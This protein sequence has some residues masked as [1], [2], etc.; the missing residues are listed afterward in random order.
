MSRLWARSFL[1]ISLATG[2]LFLAS[3]GYFFHSDGSNTLP[4][5]PEQGSSVENAEPLDPADD[6]FPLFL[7]AHWAYRD[8]T[9]DV[10]PELHAGA[11]IET[12]VVGIVRRVD[13]NTGVAYDCY[14]LRTRKI[15]APDVLSYVHRTSNSLD[16][17]GVEIVQY[18]GAPE[19]VQVSGEQ[20]I[21][22]P[23]YKGLAWGFSNPYGVALQAKVIGQEYVP[24][25]NAQLAFLGPYTNSFTHAWRVEW[26]Y[27]GPLNDAYG[28][29]DVDTWLAPGVGMVGRSA[30]SHYY[31][32]VEFRDRSRVMLLSVDFHDAPYHHDN[33]QRVGGTYD[34]TLYDVIAVQFRGEDDSASSG[35]RWEIEKDCWGTLIDKG[36]LSPL[37]SADQGGSFFS[38]FRGA[39]KLDTGSYAF[40]FKIRTAGVAELRFRRVG[41]GASAGLDDEFVFKFGAKQPMSL[42]K[43]S[44]TCV[45][46]SAGANVTFKVHYRD[47]DGLKPTVSQVVVYKNGQAPEEGTAYDMTCVLGPFA[48]GDYTYTT[49]PEEGLSP[50]PTYYWYYFHFENLDEN[51][52]KEQLDLGPYRLDVP[53]P[54]P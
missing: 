54:I 20:Y 37:W 38:D 3:C 42:D 17:Y 12:D 31:E 25:S 30:E 24:L 41:V 26:K 1:A 14:V 34:S 6:P 36:V 9:P 51:G 23:L 47:D 28:P 46:T 4:L 43:G 19:L 5:P 15:G 16:L 13:P 8:A 33:E 2:T 35:W 39:Q 27:G 45:T 18:T 7:G 48:D 50:W 29:G 32:L 11:R 10:N 52:T 49:K 21:P 53:G 40:L 44:A 22:L